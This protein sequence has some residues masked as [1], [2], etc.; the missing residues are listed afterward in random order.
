MKIFPAFIAGFILLFAA[1]AGAQVYSGISNRAN[2]YMPPNMDSQQ[3][4]TLVI[5]QWDK[6]GDGAVNIA[7]WNDAA[8]RWLG[9]SS[10]GSF[11]SWDLNHNGVLESTELR[12]QTSNYQLFH[13][14]DTN[15]DGHIDG[16]EAARIPI[17]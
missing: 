14:Y 7:E 1:G 9:R 12:S 3:F 5:S 6:N 16:A 2:V 17:Q 8:P 10:L 15:G 4:N 11:F 13:I